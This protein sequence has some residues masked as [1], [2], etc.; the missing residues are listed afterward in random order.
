MM[1]KF[2]YQIYIS[3][4]FISGFDEG[5]RQWLGTESMYTPVGIIMCTEII[6]S[7]DQLNK[8]LVIVIHYCIK[9]YSNLAGQQ[10]P[11]FPCPI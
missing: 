1:T 4:I 11:W 5:V 10:I 3:I 8:L 9:S 6:R 2:N 7:V